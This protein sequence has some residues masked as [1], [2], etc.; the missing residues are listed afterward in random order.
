ME[1]LAGMLVSHRH[2]LR[3]VCLDQQSMAGVHLLFG[4]LT[5]LQYGALELNS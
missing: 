5:H 1:R 3:A 2:D 4:E